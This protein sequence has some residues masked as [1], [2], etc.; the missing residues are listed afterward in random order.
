MTGSGQQ[1]TAIIVDDESLARKGLRLRL[2][3]LD[4]IEVVDE[5]VNGHE[6]LSSVVERKPDLVFLD[7]Q[8]PGM[9]GFDVIGNM[10]QEDMPL[11]IF[12]TAFDQYAIEAFDV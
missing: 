5:C 2:A 1:L 4:G 10:Q 8:M 3:E 6:A 7:I 9:S 12:V 11:I